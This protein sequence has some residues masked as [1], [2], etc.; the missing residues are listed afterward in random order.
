MQHTL[1][2]LSTRAFQPCSNRPDAPTFR[3]DDPAQHCLPHNSSTKSE[4]SSR[5]G[6]K[7]TD[8]GSTSDV[9]TTT[10]PQPCLQQR[11][12]LRWSAKLG[13]TPTFCLLLWVYPLHLQQALHPPLIGMSLDYSLFHNTISS[14]Y[15]SVEKNQPSEWQWSRLFKAKHPRYCSS[16]P[17]T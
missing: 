9:L 2:K 12:L 16:D 3:Y 4:A 5:T 17:R 7:E 13:Q 15:G 10:I 1:G 14:S 6:G 8:Q 11:R